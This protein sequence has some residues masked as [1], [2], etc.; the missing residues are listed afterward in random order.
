[1]GVPKQV[2]EQEAAADRAIEQAQ[3]RK[4]NPSQPQ[5]VNLSPDT[6]K[7]NPAPQEAPKA[8]AP[9][10]PAEH[11][12]SLQAQLERE[13]QLRKT[14]EGRLKS[15]LKPANEE[16]RRLREEM[17][18]LREQIEAKEAEGEKKG[19][20]AFLTDEE[21]AELGD[22]VID[23]NSRMIKGILGEELG[24]K[25]I[26][27]VVQRLMQKSNE[28]QVNTGRSGPSDDF[29]PLVDQYCP[30]AY[31]INADA[32][33]KWVSYLEE[34]NSQTGEKHRDTAE[35]AMNDDDPIALA[36]MFADF[37]RKNGKVQDAAPT[38]MSQSP[39]PDS[40]PRGMPKA[41]ATPG[42]VEPW[43]QREVTAFYTDVSK[44]KF[45]GRETE[46]DKLES[47]IMAA[48]AAG[49]IT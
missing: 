4:D 39:K 44:G 49:K 31:Q 2:L 46:A 33:P 47:E 40:A 36:D 37:M 41:P 42:Q 21:K 15:Q 1:M 8:D 14:L 5:P 23:L 24:V 17:A 20:D 12:D 9:A 30:G 43:T 3:Q 32:D 45:K 22:G 7:G 38:R 19:I 18:S 48:A 13:R 10:A 25:R 35:Q 26:E 11:V 16:I 29:W 28:A 34:Y 6:D 27:E